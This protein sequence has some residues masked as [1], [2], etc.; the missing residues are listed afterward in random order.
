MLLLLGILSGELVARALGGGFELM[1]LGLAGLR[2][3]RQSCEAGSR[4][5]GLGYSLW[6]FGVLSGKLVCRFLGREGFILC[7]WYV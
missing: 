6:L 4:M 3:S 1:L 2:E 5:Q 7:L